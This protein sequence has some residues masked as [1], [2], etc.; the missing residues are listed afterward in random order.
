M[1]G[2][3]P[4]SDDID[5]EVLSAHGLTDTE[6][7]SNEERLALEQQNAVEVDARLE[8][9]LRRAARLRQTQEIARERNRALYAA[10]R[11]LP[12]WFDPLE[13]A[14][15]A[16]SLQ[17]LPPIDF[18]EI[19]PARPEVLAGPAPEP[20]TLTSWMVLRHRLV[21]WLRRIINR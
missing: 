2:G 19:P 18:K 5:P 20:P 14:R 15:V 7:L 10:L 11:A 9:E 4:V 13:A 1:E 12:R 17:T 8:M 3:A 16:E 21:L 6:G